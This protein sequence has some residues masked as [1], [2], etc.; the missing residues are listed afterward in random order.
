MSAATVLAYLSLSL[1]LVAPAFC[2]PPAAIIG[3]WQL[4]ADASGRSWIFAFKA[5]GTETIS[6]RKG[7]T[8]IPVTSKSG[9]PP[10]FRYALSGNRITITYPNHKVDEYQF[11]VKANTLIFTKV[12]LFQSRPPEPG[13]QGSTLTRY[14]G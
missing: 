14:K 3:K 2:E 5:D 9:K 10:I 13:M 1:A 12:I 8:L 4:P 11:Q 6:P 7:K